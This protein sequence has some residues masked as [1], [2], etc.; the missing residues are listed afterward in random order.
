VVLTDSPRYDA[1]AVHRGLIRLITAEPAAVR[2]AII[3][4]LGDD[5]LRRDMGA[6]ARRLAETHFDATAGH[7]T[8]ARL[9]DD[10]L[11]EPQGALWT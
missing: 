3:D 2:Q 5:R 6:Y 7:V 1:Y 4:I 8:L 10:V 9:Y 11:L